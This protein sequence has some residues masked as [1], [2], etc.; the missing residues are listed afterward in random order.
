MRGRDLRGDMGS[1]LD[2]RL[3]DLGE[4]VARRQRDVAD[5]EHVGVSGQRE[6]LGHRDAAAATQRDAEQAGDRARGHARS[7]DDRAGGDAPTV[8]QHDGAGLDMVDTDPEF[9]VDVACRSVVCGLLGQRRM[10]RAEHPVG[11]LDQ[12][13]R[14]GRHREVGVVL[15]EHLVD[16]FPQAAGH[17]DAGR[18]T[19]DDDDA[20]IDRRAADRHSRVRTARADVT[21]S[22]SASCSVF[23]GNVLPSTPSMPNDVLIVPAAITR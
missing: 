20:E 13:D 8:L 1:S 2:R 10:E 3:G 18:S 15:A 12:R 22:R 19:T 7:P 21:R 16:Q 6:I 14:R 9:D 23:S 11:G 17:L 5:R 4:R